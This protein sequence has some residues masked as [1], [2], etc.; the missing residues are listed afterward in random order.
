MYTRIT[1]MGR[2]VVNVWEEP[3]T[4]EVPT[5]MLGAAIGHFAI[6]GHSVFLAPGTYRL[7]VVA[8]D[9]VGGTLNNYEMAL[10]VPRFEEDKLASS[11][12]LLADLIETLPTRSV[13]AGQFVIGD[14]KVR[15]RLTETFRRDEK[16]GIYFQLYNFAPD[17]KTQKPNGQIQYEI[18]KNGSN[19]S[20]F[21]FSEEVTALPGASAQQVTVEHILPLAKMEPG[22]YTLRMKVTDRIRNQVLTPSATF[23]VK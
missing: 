19:K 21:D 23:T 18:T 20:V 5:A 2:R 14:S 13:G 10:R 4:A 9:V 15:P 22:Q 7:N 8:K 16:L 1:S 12:V 6:Y 3:V 11:T 17:E